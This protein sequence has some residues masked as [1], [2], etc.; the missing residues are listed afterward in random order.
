MSLLGSLGLFFVGLFVGYVIPRV[1]LVFFSRL[2]S[3]NYSFSKHPEPVKVTPELLGRLLTMR[4]LYWLGLLY[5]IPPIIFGWLI[6]RW[7]GSALGFGLLLA[8]GWTVLARVLPSGEYELQRYPYSMRIVHSLHDVRVRCRLNDM[9]PTNHDEVMKEPCCGIPDPIW[10]V[11]AVRCSN[12]RSILLDEP[13]PD[14]GR[15][16]SDGFFRGSLRVMLLDGSPPVHSS[17]SISSSI[18]MSFSDEES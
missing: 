11:A 17:P 4:R 12:C 14:L 6:I 13:R 18:N 2:E 5:S 10:E 8:G 15:V 9:L 7:S 16:R 1:P 3:L